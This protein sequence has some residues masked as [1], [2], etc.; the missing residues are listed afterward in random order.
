MRFEALAAMRLGGSGQ[1]W[2]FVGA[3]VWKFK[4]GSLGWFGGM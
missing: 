4:Q 3:G 1:M 2:E